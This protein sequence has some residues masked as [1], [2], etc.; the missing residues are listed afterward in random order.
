MKAFIDK[1]V[2]YALLIGLGIGVVAALSTFGSSLHAGEW[3]A[4]SSI[5]LAIVAFGFIHAGKARQA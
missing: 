4:G 1:V 5:S 2:A 3:G